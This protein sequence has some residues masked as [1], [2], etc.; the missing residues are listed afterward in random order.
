MK[1]VRIQRGRQSGGYAREEGKR[2]KGRWGS[3]AMR[4]RPGE[5]KVGGVLQNKR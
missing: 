1:V 2:G 5:K 4:G 3:R